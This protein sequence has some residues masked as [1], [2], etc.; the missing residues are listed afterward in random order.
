M[1]KHDIMKSSIIFDLDST[2]VTI[3]GL[4]YLATLKGVEE[5]VVLLTTA[6]MNGAIAMNA[7]MRIKMA[8][9]KPGKEDMLHLGNHYINCLVPGAKQVI[10]KLKNLGHEIYIVTGNFIPSALTVANYLGINQDQVYANQIYFDGRGKYAGFDYHHPLASNGGKAEVIKQINGKLH[11]PI[12]IGDGITD[13]ETRE[14][15]HKFIGFGGVV[16]RPAVKQAA[17]VYIDNLSLKQLLKY[18]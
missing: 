9:I 13:L 3:E 7:A 6:A 15:V 8:L 17:E 12:M 1:P 11:R 18:I 2:L 16:V 5:E 10:N 4:D 14:V